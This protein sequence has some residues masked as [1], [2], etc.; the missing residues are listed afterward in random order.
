MGDQVEA[1]QAQR[2][3][4]RR[5]STAEHICRAAQPESVFGSPDVM[6]ER[7]TDATL[8]VTEQLA[9][10]I[11]RAVHGK[12]S[13]RAIEAAIH[14]AARGF[15]A[16]KIARP[17]ERELLHG[18]M[19][20]ALDAA[21]E[22]HTD[23][24]IAVESFAAL[25]SAHRALAGFGVDTR[26]S[27][28]P[29]AE[30]IQAFLK[31]QAVTREDFDRMKKAAQVRAFTV[32]NAANE[33]MVKTVKQE[34]TRQLAAGADLSD[35][36]KHAAERFEQAGWT[37]AS[38]SH[39][40]TV[41][42]TNVLGSYG[43]GRVRQMTQP[44]VLDARPFW[45]WLSC[46]DGPPR[47]R[48]TH[49]AMHG[50][51]LRASDPFWSECYPPAGYNCRCRVRSLSI[52]QGAGKVEEGRGGRFA[53]MPDDGF[54]SGIGAMFGKESEPEREPANDVERIAAEGGANDTERPAAE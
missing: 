1:D 28:K 18:A 13:K 9:E 42:R 40:A 30:A 54:S 39:V 19:L 29:L 25:H 31:K 14:S 2:G 20:G 37:P 27:S 5:L 38:G 47:Q 21:W 3:A 15:G 26:F 41:F 17:I 53:A 23:R 50:A 12:S 49:A 45:Q 51:V 16:R 36:G 33:A 52:R 22:A 34:L 8:H 24:P 46:N 10:A 32:A 11:V 43:Q 48:R 7:G 44:D 6:V 4:A 35:F